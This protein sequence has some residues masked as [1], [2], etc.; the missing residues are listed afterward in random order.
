MGRWAGRRI[1]IAF[2]EQNDPGGRTGR[3]ANLRERIGEIRAMDKIV[4]ATRNQGKIREIREIFRGIPVMTMDEAGVHIEIEETGTTFEE[5]AL[6][7]ARDVFR[8]LS[9]SE[10]NAL[11]MSDDSGIEIDFLGGEPGVYSAR[12]LGVD[13][14][15]EIKNRIILEKLAEAKGEARSA[16]Y[17]CAIAAVAPDGREVC[18]RQTVEGFISEEPA[19]NGGFGYDPIFFVPEYG[20]T[21]AQLRPEEKNQISHR[22]KALRKMRDQLERELLCNKRGRE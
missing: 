22:G 15:Y 3:S 21:M 18:L 4:F 10:E 8:A 5:N 17:V 9:G 6:L 11:V 7:K 13:T 16:R 19:G 1:S 14:P 20:K 12:F 2:A